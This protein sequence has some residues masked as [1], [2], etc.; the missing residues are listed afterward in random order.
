M[1]ANDSF[2]HSEDLLLFQVLIL[3]YSRWKRI[4]NPRLSRTSSW[5]SVVQRSEQV[6]LL[7]SQIRCC[8]L[9]RFLSGAVEKG[10]A[11]LKK[12][13]PLPGEDT[14]RNQGWYDLEAIGASRAAWTLNR[15]FTQRRTPVEDW[16]LP[17]YSRFYD[18]AWVLGLLQ[19]AAI[20]A[21]ATSG[22]LDSF[23]TG[24]FNN[25]VRRMTGNY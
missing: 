11:A 13:P 2:I 10:P 12:A 1:Y 18:R 14:M 23:W 5:N 8:L 17:T 7:Q 22:S 20:R 16:R 3:H 24:H 19:G 9:G 21:H 6:F 25:F 4:T 15:E